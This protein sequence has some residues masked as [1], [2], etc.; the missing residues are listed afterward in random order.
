MAETMSDSREEVMGSASLFDLFCEY[1]AR[2]YRSRW[3]ESHPLPSVPGIGITVALAFVFYLFQL[4]ALVA[5]FA[6]LAIL[7]LLW[8][9]WAM[10]V[11]ATAATAAHQEEI[12]RGHFPADAS[13]IV[14]NRLRWWNHLIVPRQWARHS[15]IHEYK[16]R[17]EQKIESLTH[18][19]ETLLAE[20]EDQKQR[21]A[22]LPRPDFLALAA[23][24]NTLAERVQYEQRMADI[25]GELP[26]LAEELSFYQALHHKVLGMTEKLDSIDRL[27]VVISGAEQRDLDHVVREALAVFE[28]RRQLVEEV[29]AV[30]PDGFLALVK[31]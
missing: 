12:R 14:Y 24:I 27:S 28:K 7:Q 9:F 3:E 8:L 16:F 26:R 22:D 10:V 2:D 25:S 19:I 5:L 15:R 23:K 18:R 17:L 20:Q 29:D 1:T 4:A 21:L 6:L 30:D 13:S 11:R 31:A